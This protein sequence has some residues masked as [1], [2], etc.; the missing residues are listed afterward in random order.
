MSVRWRTR[1]GVVCGWASSL[2]QI[3][4]CL[5]ALFVWMHLPGGVRFCGPSVCCT[6]EHMS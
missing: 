5:F 6:V 3:W 1:L 2:H 4:S